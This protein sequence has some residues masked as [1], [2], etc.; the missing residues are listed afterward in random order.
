LA[1]FA[2]TAT[3]A[4]AH[5]LSQG[6][7]DVTVHPDRVSV[8]ARVTLEEVAVTNML[9]PAAP[10]E[11]VE[12]ATSLAA[13]A[14]AA[15]YAQHSRYLARHLHV[16]ADGKP[17]AG[18]VLRVLTQDAAAPAPGGAPAPPNAPAGHKAEHV[19]YELEYRPA[20]SPSPAAAAPPG[21]V[22]LRQD[23]LLGVDY[24]PG[25]SWEASYVVRIRC[26]EGPATEGLLLTSR[27]P[28]NFTCDWSPAGPA[29]AG[30]QAVRVERLQ[31]VRDYLAHGVHHIL[32]GYDHLLFIGALVL[33]AT[34]LW[35]LVKVVS[36]FT[37]AHTLTLTL[38]ALDVFRLPSGIVEPLIAA[39][40]VFVAVQNIFWPD[41]SR[42]W[43]RLAAAFF[44]GL[45]HGLGFA[46]GL[47]EAMEGMSGGTVLLAIAAFSVGVEV[48]HQVIVIP[49][50]AALKL[51]RRS[52][53][54]GDGRER[55]SLLAQRYG[56][57]LISVAGMFYLVLALRASLAGS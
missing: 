39:S 51:A 28:L 13:D 33:A 31:L 1:L 54:D 18:T 26:G 16:S 38:S 11:T 48:G 41:R 4:R 19:L 30:T 34:T 8:R 50:F 9:V 2:V 32:S 24:A 20:E 36:A 10:G 37:L 55:V 27:G 15:A 17:M 22:E 3:P 44:F 7:L 29:T 6:A 52:R 45:F 21:R 23:V 46:G 42:G 5:P 56:S 57:A 53:P 14:M 49:L 25:T 35:D 43:V 12:P 40:I 47:L